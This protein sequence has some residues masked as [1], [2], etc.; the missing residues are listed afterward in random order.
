MP[1]SSK[2]VQA[3]KDS[4]LLRS[5]TE[6]SIPGVYRE[7]DRGQIGRMIGEKGLGVELLSNPNIHLL[8]IRYR[9][10]FFS[11]AGDNPEEWE[12]ELEGELNEFEV[13]NGSGNGGKAGEANPEWENQIEEMLEAEEQE[14]QAKK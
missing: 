9:I 6:A 1:K 2:R 4:Q 7:R 5:R 12:A 13:V 14:Q 10:Y 3:W 11:C 8:K